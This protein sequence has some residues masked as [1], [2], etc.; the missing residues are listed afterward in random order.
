MRRA[1]PRRWCDVFAA[2]AGKAVDEPGIDDLDIAD[3]QQ[4]ERA[5]AVGRDKAAELDP[6]RMVAPAGEGPAPREPIA[7]I[8][9]RGGAGGGEAGAG[10]R[11]ILARPDL[12]L[13]L[14]RIV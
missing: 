6:A 5:L 11:F 7:A 2:G 3:R 9:Q 13:R 8:D 12:A 1:E 10:Q 4:K 14:D